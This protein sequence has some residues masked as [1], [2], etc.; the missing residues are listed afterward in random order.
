MGTLK[1]GIMPRDQFQ[2]RT[3]AIAAGHYKPKKGEPK[4]WFNSIKS[5]A[6]V[7]SENN[8]RLIKIID[9]RK[10]ETLK[11]LSELSG[12]A[13]SNLSRTLKTLERYGIV[14]L[15]RQQRALK[16]VAKAT[17]FDIHYAA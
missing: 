9:E 6:E 7:L 13:V 12:R 10:P 16:P 3:L 17:S 8:I 15:V 1:V 2:A 14:E 4:I 5:L 11:E